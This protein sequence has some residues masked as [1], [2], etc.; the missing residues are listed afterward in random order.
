MS[1]VQPV[2]TEVT[3]ASLREVMSRFATGVVVLT[4]GGDNPHGMTANSFTS[5]SLEPPTVLCC[6]GHSAVMHS[7]LTRAGRFGVSVMSAEQEETTRYFADKKRPLGPAQFE[8]LDWLPGPGTGAPLLSGALAWLEC[9]VTAAHEVG[10]H[11]VFLGEVVSAMN[12]A[13]GDGL[14]FYEGRFQR[15]G[16]TPGR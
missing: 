3:P 13:A 1:P 9:E 6:I 14:L 15:T 7:A 10:D 12:G 11:S 16:T 5:V 4:V 2:A 8:R